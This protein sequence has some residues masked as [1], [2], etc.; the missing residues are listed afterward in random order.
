M[1]RKATKSESLLRTQNIYGRLTQGQ[2]RSRIIRECSEEW[3]CSTR[4]VENYLAKAQKLI[5]DDCN[6]ARPAFLAECL[7][8][9]RAIR[10]QATTAGS[11]QTALN[12]IR[13]MAELTGLDSKS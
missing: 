2:A 9:I 3:G 4:Q 11:H 7:S 12:A 10:E 13:L 5:I 8:G 6:M 1:G